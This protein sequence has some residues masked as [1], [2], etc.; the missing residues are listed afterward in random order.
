M[1]EQNKIKTKWIIN[2]YNLSCFL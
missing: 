2:A 1:I